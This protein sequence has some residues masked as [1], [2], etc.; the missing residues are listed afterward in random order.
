MRVCATTMQILTQIIFIAYPKNP[1]VKI[2]DQAGRPKTHHDTDSVF[3]R[4]KKGHLLSIVAD[5]D[6]DRRAPVA[7]SGHR[8]VTG[9]TQPVA[10]PLFLHKVWHP[11]QHNRSVVV[12]RTTD[13]GNSKSDT[14]QIINNK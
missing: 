5:P 3:R 13:T 12:S 6:R 7:V 8:P 14:S 10:K 1:L 4:V 2:L 9:V 11:V